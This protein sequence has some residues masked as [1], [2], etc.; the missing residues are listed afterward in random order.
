M[1]YWDFSYSILDSIVIG[2]EVAKL[3][4]DYVYQFIV[5]LLMRLYRNI[6]YEWKF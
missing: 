3:I 6:V 2:V 4:I 5:Y 1:K